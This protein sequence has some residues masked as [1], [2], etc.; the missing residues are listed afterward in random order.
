MGWQ[1]GQE[2]RKRDEVERGVGEWTGKQGKVPAYDLLDNSP[3]LAGLLLHIHDTSHYRQGAPAEGSASY[4]QRTSARRMSLRYWVNMLQATLMMMSGCWSMP[5]A[6]Q[7][8]K[9]ERSCDV[10]HYHHHHILFAKKGGGLPE[11]PKLIIRWSPIMLDGTYSINNC[12]M[13]LYA[14]WCRM[15]TVMGSL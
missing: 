13:P 12:G 3:M 1:K 2:G 4:G 11:K 10:N 15:G 14:F 5:L 7:L 6:L 8:W 9:K